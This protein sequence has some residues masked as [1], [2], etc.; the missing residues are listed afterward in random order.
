M[1]NPTYTDEQKAEALRIYVEQ[2][3]TAAS[4]AIGANKGTITRWAKNAGLRT[5]VT[6]NTQ[7]ATAAA[8]A[9]AKQRRTELA[10]L[11]LE[12]AHKLRQQL[13]Q[14][15][16]VHAF[17]GKDNTYEEHELPEPTFVDKKNILSAVGV[18]VDRVVKLEQLDATPGDGAQA[19]ESVLDKLL[20]S[21][22]QAYAAGKDAPQ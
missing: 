3:P 12:D 20:D 22:G 17:G 7:A 2:G 15:A 11:L 18:A 6:P 19:A 4:Q 10:M 13:W 16:T 9:Q 14:P 21:F 1:A 8:S 5:N